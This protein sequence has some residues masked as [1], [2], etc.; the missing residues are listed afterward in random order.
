VGGNPGLGADVELAVTT[1][2]ETAVQLFDRVVEQEDRHAWGDAL[3]QLRFPRHK[4][5]D[6]ALHVLLDR[7][8]V[9]VEDDAAQRLVGRAL[10]VVLPALRLRLARIARAVVTTISTAPTVATSASTITAAA[11]PTSAATPAAPPIVA[12]PA[13]APGV[14]LRRV[15]LTRLR[16]GNRPSIL[17]HRAGLTSR[18]FVCADSQA[19]V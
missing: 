19:H 2:N 16:L 17:G 12:R 3:N 8:V 4:S 9:A 6:H 1:R 11:T 14:T 5:K 10:R 18:G 7:L 13:S 15:V